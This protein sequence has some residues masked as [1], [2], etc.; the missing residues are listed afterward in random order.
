MFTADKI[1]EP[2]RIAITQRDEA[3]VFFGAAP[4]DLTVIS[5]S[6]VPP[7]RGGADWLYLPAQLLP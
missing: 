1:G 5:R 2:M 7:V 4:P 6:D 3:K